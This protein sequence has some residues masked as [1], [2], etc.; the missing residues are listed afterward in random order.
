MQ[1]FA[2]LKSSE[3]TYPVLKLCYVAVILA[4]GTD[5]IV[6]GPGVIS[7]ENCHRI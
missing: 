1:K 5:V 4:H 2:E 7:S 6:G 3:S